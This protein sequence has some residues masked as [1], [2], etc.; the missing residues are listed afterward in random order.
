[1]FFKKVIRRTLSAPKIFI[2]KLAIRILFL[3][4]V[5]ACSESKPKPAENPFLGLWELVAVE[6]RLED[7]TLD[8]DGFASYVGDNEEYF[9]AEDVKNC[10]LGFR[11]EFEESSYRFYKSIDNSYCREDIDEGNGT[12]SYDQNSVD[13]ISGELFTDEGDDGV[14]TISIESNQLKIV[15]ADADLPE[16][17][18]V[19]LI[20]EKTNP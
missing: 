1:M 6:Y 5:L 20:F 10:F 11:I 12:Y 15:S 8:L 7:E 16:D 3:T 4:L 17:P 14:Q 2:M 9:S 18:V 13:E 19:V